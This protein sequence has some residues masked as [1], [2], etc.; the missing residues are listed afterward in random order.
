MTAQQMKDEI[1]QFFEHFRKTSA[2]FRKQLTPPSHSPAGHELLAGKMACCALLDAL[3]VA[4][5]PNEKGHGKR[6][7]EF[8]KAFS[9]WEYWDKVSIPQLLYRLQR[10]G[11]SADDRL[12]KHVEI[13]L[14]QRQEY[15][16]NQDPPSLELIKCFPE[17]ERVIKNCC[18]LYLFYDY[19]C[20]LIHEMREPGYGYEFE[21]TMKPCYQ[22]QMEIPT[23]RRTLQLTYPLMFFFDLCDEC[24][25]NLEQY[26]LAENRSP[27]DAYESRF[28]DVWYR[29]Q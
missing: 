3:S 10:S 13:R 6:S 12:K 23:G 26:F 11:G 22:G 2:Y 25:A 8:V 20:A 18:H 29:P 14:A 1:R 4:R 9:K 7:R 21:H 28:G 19:R 24:I 27:F 17:S 5:F 15:A 16:I